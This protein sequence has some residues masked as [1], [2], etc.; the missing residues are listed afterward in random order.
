MLFSACQPVEPATS[1]P[2]T[3]PTDGWEVIDGEEATFESIEV[4]ILESF[5]VQ[6]NVNVTGYLP[7]GCVTL[8]GIGATRDGTEFTLTPFTH[9]P[10]GEVECTE[11]QVPFEESVALEVFGLPAGTYTV[12]AQEQTATF[13][14]DV[15]NVLEEPIIGDQ[16]GGEGASMDTGVVYL[17]SMTV[18]V[19][20]SFP[21]QVSVTLTGNL[22]DGCTKLQ[23][24]E[25]EQD[26][27]T[28]TLL[29][30]A[31]RPAGQMCTQALV[32]FEETVSLDVY[33][34]PAGEY[35]VMAG[36]LTESFTFDVDNTP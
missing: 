6:V 27:Q 21:V 29:V 10:A 33:G 11:A 22:A 3:A 32:P 36:D 34:L 20:E 17:D 7:D 35:T 9:R 15:D 25:V 30:T 19:M 18:N 14:L 1:E 4:L 23:T 8:D 5:P 28:F 24:I 12:R 2:T 26:G 31:K 13:T 16:E